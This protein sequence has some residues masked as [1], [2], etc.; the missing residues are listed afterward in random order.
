M[1]QFGVMSYIIIS[2]RR[3]KR[4]QLV[5]G[6]SIATMTQTHHSVDP[7][8]PPAVIVFDQT[9]VSSHAS[10]VE[11]TDSTSTS[12]LESSI[13]LARARHHSI[14][15]S[16]GEK[17]GRSRIAAPSTSNLP[18]VYSGTTLDLLVDDTV[19]GTTGSD[20]DNL[21]DDASGINL[22]ITTEGPGSG[23]SEPSSSSFQAE[24]TGN[25]SRS[26]SSL[27]GD[28]ER[29]RTDTVTESSV[30]AARDRDGIVLRTIRSLSR[31]SAGVAEILRARSLSR[32]SVGS[33]TPPRIATSANY[34]PMPQPLENHN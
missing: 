25:M 27:H 5:T 33:Q 3:R 9:G 32:I 6:G 4:R 18:T 26:Q 14:P 10:E 8:V 16:V 23:N 22:Q 34:S 31:S 7:E 1:S 29:E 24:A 2:V 11:A 17:S 15:V 20:G 30:P 12:Q 19:T 21:N 28:S 13:P